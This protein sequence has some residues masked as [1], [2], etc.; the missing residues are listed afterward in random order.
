MI[1]VQNPVW[2]LVL[3]NSARRAHTF[4]LTAD[5]F[6]PHPIPYALYWMETRWHER[7]ADRHAW[8][9][10]AYL[11][12]RSFGSAL[13]PIS[14]GTPAHIE[15]SSPS[16]QPQHTDPL[17]KHSHLSTQG[18]CSNHQ[19]SGASPNYSPPRIAPSDGDT[20]IRKEVALVQGWSI[21]VSQ[22]PTS[23]PTTHP[24][25]QPKERQETARA[26]LLEVE[27]TRVPGLDSGLWT[28]NLD[29]TNPP[30]KGQVYGF[31]L[32]CVF[33]EEGTRLDQ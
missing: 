32:S 17:T 20:G 7:Q 29:C 5:R 25:L 24:C 9:K 28:W 23:L 3:P 13:I 18:Q 26:G 30:C 27:V 8:Y 19:F 14:I 12:Y 31:F 11:Q 2:G 1:T 16:C 6:S 21:R 15:P 4:V 10:S 33:C 22:P